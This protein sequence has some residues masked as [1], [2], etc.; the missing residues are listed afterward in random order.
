MEAYHIIHWIAVNPIGTVSPTG[1]LCG[2]QPGAMKKSRKEV[3][4]AEPKAQPKTQPKAEPKA[5]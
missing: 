2:S 3:G 4:Y 5:S 1:N